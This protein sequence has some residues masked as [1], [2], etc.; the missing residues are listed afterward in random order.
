MMSG[1]AKQCAV[2]NVVVEAVACKRASRKLVACVNGLSQ[3]LSRLV[4]FVGADIS[5]II[6]PASADHN[7]TLEMERGHFCLPGRRG[8]PARCIPRKDIRSFSRC[9]FLGG[10]AIH[11][12]GQSG[13]E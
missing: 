7:P 6:Q 8:D 4:E 12:A 2:A 10:L 5:I 1:Q 9:Y 13:M 11:L 3:R